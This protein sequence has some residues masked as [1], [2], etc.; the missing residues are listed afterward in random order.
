MTQF[1]TSEQVHKRLCL[2]VDGYPTQVDA[3]K[4]LKVSRT[5]LNMLLNKKRSIGPGVIA[6]LGLVPVCITKALA[7]SLGK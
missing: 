7:L 1:L 6:E 5:H 4:A 2:F 3:A